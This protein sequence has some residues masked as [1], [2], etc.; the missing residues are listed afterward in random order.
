MTPRVL[1]IGAGLTGAVTASLLR[2]ELQGKIQIVI[3]DKGRGA[4]GRMSTSR[5]PGNPQNSVDLGAQYIT[6]T[7]SYA[8][9]HASFYEELLSKN[10]IRPFKGRIEGEKQSQDKTTNFVTPQG[11]SS[12][13]KYFLS[14]AD[15]DVH[16]NQRVTKIDETE[17]D[18]QTY[19]TADVDCDAGENVTNGLLYD[20]VVITMPVPQAMALDGIVKQTFDESSD[21]KSLLEE[22]IYS[23]RY[24]LGLFY[25]PAAAIN[26]PWAAKYEY[27]NPCIRWISLDT[28][29]RGVDSKNIGASVAV[30]T[31]VPFS[32][33]RLESDKDEVQ[34]M[35]M[36]QLKEVVPNL[37]EPI[38]IK[39]Q[40]WRYSQVFKGVKGQPG[41]M[42]V[43]ETPSYTVIMGGDA[44][45]HSNFDGCIS[46]A[47]IV[48]E[49]LL[50]FLHSSGKID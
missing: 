44:F 23:S 10:V 49:Q 7:S 38:N 11:I 45:T 26:Q 24:A 46:S 33:E 13:V 47:E 2:R 6:Q 5:C 50:T 35:V 48:T 12:V 34:S 15:A 29:K 36:D 19:L 22:V 20:A 4:G 37:P 25:G 18:G 31:S 17:K 28:K 39:C 3:L 9:K 27:T 43:K 41:A 40:R 21:K 30:H 42:V 14:Q 32:L 8:S 1:I 16:F